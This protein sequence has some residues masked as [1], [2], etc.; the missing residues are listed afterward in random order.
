MGV[1]ISTANAGATYEP[2][3]TQTASGSSATISFTSIPSTYTD[4]ILVVNG[5]LSAGNNTRMRL[6]NDTSADYSMTVLAGDG[7]NASSYRD[8]SQTSFSYPG[9]YDTAMGM[10]IFHFQSYSNTS[11]NKTF[12]QRNSKASN[13]AQAAVGLWRISSAIN[14]IDFYTASGATWTTSTTATLYGIRA[15]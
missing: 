8:S 2:I 15:A 13:Q 10:N 9:F 3:A 5:S 6:N 7:T 12:L 4:L 14:Q 1:T 11:I